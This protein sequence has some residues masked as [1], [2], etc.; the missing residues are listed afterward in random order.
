M[1]DMNLRKGEKCSEGGKCKFK[2]LLGRY[3]EGKLKKEDPKQSD[4]T[5]LQV[6]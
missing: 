1:N 4:E 3:F 2:T 5:S 6:M